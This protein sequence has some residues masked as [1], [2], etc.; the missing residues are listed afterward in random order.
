[1]C[2]YTHLCMYRDTSMCACA[3]G[4]SRWIPGIFPGDYFFEAGS[5]NQAQNLLA[6]LLQGSPFW[7]CEDE[8]IGGWPYQLDIHVRFGDPRSGLFDCWANTYG[9]S[10]LPSS[11]KLLH[12]LTVCTLL[13]SPC[14]MEGSRCTMQALN[15]LT[16]QQLGYRQLS[17]VFTLLRNRSGQALR[18]KA[19]QLYNINDWH[20]L[21]ILSHFSSVKK[22]PPMR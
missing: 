2:A 22:D 16:Q 10:H 19:C 3:H 18:I 1:M 4:D 13:G 11:R 5:L 21:Y 7:P 6:S 8:I 15:T 14:Y 9:L 20:T 17:T 12:H